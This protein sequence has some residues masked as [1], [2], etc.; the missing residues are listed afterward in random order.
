MKVWSAQR[1]TL[2]A[3]LTL[4]LTVAQAYA[5]QSPADEDELALLY[6]AADS[7]SIAT[8]NLQALRRAPAVASVITA[9]DIAAMG[10]T[11]LDQVLES[12]PGIHVNRTPNSNSPLYVVRG[13]V[14]PYTPQILM[15]QNGV[16]ITT[17]YVGNKGNIWG[18]Y[19]VEHIARIEIIRGPGSALYGSDAFSG[20]INIITKGPL[21]AQ[22]TEVGA[23]AGTFD[24]YDAWVQHGGKV[25]PVDVAAYVRMGSTDGNDSRIDADAQSRNDTLFRSHA[26]LAPGGLNNQVKA[27]DA[28]L[29]LIYGQWRARFGYKKRYD[30]GTGA[31]IASALDPVG[32]QR[33][34]RIT[35][36]L[37]WA[38]PQF[39]GD[40]GLGAS[41]ST[42]QYSQEV[43]T[44]YRLLPPGLVFPTGAFP[45][46][47]I[48]APETW[49]RTYRLSGYA[50]YSGLNAHHLRIGVGHD[51]IDLYR[52]REV[53]NFSYAANGTPIPL[54]SVIETTYTL[55][56]LRPQRRRIDYVYLQDEWNLAKDWNLTAGVRRDRYSDFG[57]TTNPRLALVWDA[58]F[59]LTAKLLYGRAFRAPAFL[60]SYGITNPV[61]MGNPNLKPERNATSELSFAWQA[62]A[63][64]NVNLTFYRY[65]MKNIIRVVPNATPGTG[66]T[67]ANTGNQNG[68]GVELESTW[69]VTRDLRLSGNYAWQRS[70][71]E[72]TDTDAGYAPHNHLYGRADWAFVSGYQ[73]GTQVNWVAGRKRAFG[74]AR[75]AI[76]DY[77]TLDL[78]LATRN[79]RRQWNFSAALRN[80]FNADVREPT[81]AP[82]LNLPHDLPMAPRTI[83]LQAS[84]RM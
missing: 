33:S 5:G 84:Y 65:A 69:T 3:A 34:E 44:L 63:D 36:S 40:W 79:G 16:P 7:V 45:D 19:P 25:G 83:S 72:T 2:T 9:A 73:A 18:G 59:D 54:P 61:A 17:A 49:E 62:R 31:G 24:T 20:V 47:M 68:R 58:S 77:T 57:G 70:I 53:R 37:A 82:G 14:S 21:E 60:E 43:T 30:M 12:V 71:D 74:D 8:G 39:S 32:R 29:D 38:D 50:D 1:L 41:L 26:S 35:S 66:G 48:G 10:A 52:V 81:P 11:D 23:R 42:Q 27:A 56:F 28:N 80:V 15:L 55:P 22:G 4:P 13:I 76:S 51:D 6:G 46:G 64:A 67:Y 78:T 75:P